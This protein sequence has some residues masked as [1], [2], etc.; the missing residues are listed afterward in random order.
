MTPKETRGEIPKFL[1][2]VITK[3]DKILPEIPTPLMKPTPKLRT[4]V[5]YNS[6]KQEPTTTK[7]EVIEIL[8]RKQRSIQ[9]NFQQQVP[10]LHDSDIG[11][12]IKSKQ[13]KLLKNQNSNREG[14]LLHAFKTLAKNKNDSNSAENPMVALIQ[15]LKPKYETEN[16]APQLKNTIK[17]LQ[18]EHKIVT[19]LVDLYLNKVRQEQTCFLLINEYL[20]KQNLGLSIIQPIKFITPQLKEQ[21]SSR[22][23]VVTFLNLPID[24][25]LIMI[26]AIVVEGQ[27][28][29]P[30]RNYPTRTI[31]TFSENAKIADPIHPNIQESIIGILLPF[32]SLKK[33]K[34]NY[35]KKEPTKTKLKLKFFRY[36]R[37]QYSQNFKLRV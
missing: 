30:H 1:L 12:A 15:I 7:Q 33:L 26:N 36:S 28:P 9:M 13:N 14:F 17:N 10:S 16:Y 4:V 23:P 34:R 21:P 25:S 5:G 6:G 3:E 29:N 2:Q 31:A 8:E 24:Y 18:K 19:H 35:P 32:K 11:K 27:I 37:S 22:K 20:L